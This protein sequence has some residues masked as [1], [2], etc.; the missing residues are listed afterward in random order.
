MSETVEGG[1]KERTLRVPA[2]VADRL[3][4]RLKG[5]AFSSLDEFVAYVLARVAEAESEG[6]PF[7]EEAERQLRERLRSLGYID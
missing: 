6:T 4:A 5:T 3:E 2:S 7:S 1:S